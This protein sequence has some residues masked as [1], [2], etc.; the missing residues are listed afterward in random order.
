MFSR[1]NVYVLWSRTNPSVRV[2]AVPDFSPSPYVPRIL[3]IFSH[4]YSAIGIAEEVSTTIK[5]FDNALKMPGINWRKRLETVGVIDS[6]GRGLGNS[7]QEETLD[8]AMENP[9]I[10]QLLRLD[11][12]LYEHAVKV[13]QQQASSYDN[14]EWNVGNMN[15]YLL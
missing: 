15:S 12:L 9:R 5:L 8:H 6:A 13:F 14:F 11:L 3:Y 7:E 10:R 4:R 2:K 1:D